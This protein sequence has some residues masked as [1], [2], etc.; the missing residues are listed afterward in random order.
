M[1]FLFANSAGDTLT[2]TTLEDTLFGQGGDDILNGLGGDD[3]LIDGAGSD[4][5]NGGG[6]NDLLINQGGQG[7]TFNGGAGNDTLFDEMGGFVS[8]NPAFTHII[9]DL[10][11]GVRGPNHFPNDDILNSIENY[12][13]RGSLN[14]FVY[15]TNGAN[16]LETSRGADLL[17]G[18]GGADTLMGGAGKDRLY[19][20]NGNDTLFGELGADR[21]YGGKGQDRLDG[22]RGNDKLVGGS[23]ADTFVFLKGNDKDRVTDF[24]ASLDSLAFDG[25]YFTLGQDG[26]D[27]VAAYA[28][29]SNGNVV[30]DM[31]DGDTL[32]LLGVS[33][34]SGLGDTIEIA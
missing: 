19:G 27:F 32:T 28:S 26:A 5:L 10:A 25:D 1:A 31:G 21:L 13:A 9:V 3:V 29:V 12:E 24:N 20:D 6:G 22:G 8:Q 7:D 2:G 30:F 17:R 11:N 33:S 16:L 15:G 23:G 4:T 34:L 14:V 18:A